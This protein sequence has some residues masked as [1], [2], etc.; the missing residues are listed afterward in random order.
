LHLSN[1]V[2]LPE[3]PQWRCFDRFN[4]HFS[5]FLTM[6]GDE[7]TSKVTFAPLS[8]TEIDYGSTASASSPTGSEESLDND[9]DGSQSF[10]LGMK[11]VN[12]SNIWTSVRFTE[13]F[14]EFGEDYKLVPTHLEDNVKLVVDENLNLNEKGLM[15]YAEVRTSNAP[16]LTSKVI[17]NILLSNVDRMSFTT[18]KK[19]LNMPSLFPAISIKRSLLR[20][21]ML[22]VP[23]AVY[24]FVAM[25][26]ILLMLV[27]HM[28]I[29]WTFVLH[30][31]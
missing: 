19:S 6:S 30:G 16:L 26:V 5:L 18:W 25:G 9:D 11:R 4:I 10:H 14:A 12:A 20:L 23:H 13:S 1:S 21:A 28:M 22:I 3:N 31:Y 8:T 17:L 2:L 27:Y 7:Y 15:Y 29:M 24:T